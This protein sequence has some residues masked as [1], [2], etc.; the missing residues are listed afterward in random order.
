MVVGWYIAKVARKC[1]RRIGCEDSDRFSP[2]MVVVEIQTKSQ[3]TALGSC[4]IK[5]K[6]FAFEVLKYRI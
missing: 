1:S 4:A 2:L 5:N 6:S 3:M